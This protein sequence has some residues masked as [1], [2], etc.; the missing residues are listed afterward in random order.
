MNRRTF[1]A[2]SAAVAATATVVATGTAFASTSSTSGIV[3]SATDEGKWKG[4]NGSH[5]PSIHVGG[6][7]VHVMTKHG[8]SAE[9]FIVRHT[10][11]GAD[12]TVLGS[13]TFTP[14]DKPASTFTLPAGYKG[15]LT[16]TS[17]CNLHD[18]WITETTV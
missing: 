17:F 2:T 10:L 13:Q 18:L 14:T 1:L 8:M 4:K 12:G 3:Y 16:A 7:N 15:K 6:T 5:A 9:H 11:V